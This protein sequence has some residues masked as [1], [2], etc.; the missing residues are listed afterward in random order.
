MVRPIAFASNPE[1]AGTNAFQ[2]FA[3]APAQAQAQAGAIAEFTRLRD[4]LREA[5]VGVVE[6][7]DTPE[8]WTPDSIF[9]NNWFSTHADGSY[10]LYPMLAPNRRRERRDDVFRE[11]LPAA[12]YAVGTR[13][14]LAPA[15]QHG[16][17]LE[18]TGSLV[19]DRVNRVAYACRS[20][21]THE[22]IA[23]AFAE[24]C[25]YE[26]V[27]FDARDAAGQAIYHTNVLMAVGEHFAVICAEAIPA[28][29]REAVLGRLRASGRDIID[30]SFAQM[31]GFAGNVLEL[32]TADGGRVVAMS[33][34]AWEAFTP[35]QRERL[36]RRARLLPVDIS[37]IEQCAGGSVRCMLAEVHL[38]RAAG[39]T[40]AETGA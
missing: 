24:R 10:V 13:I 23:R 29:E 30:I 17:F 3:E 36:G 21:R 8:S 37:T 31:N 38:P 16:Q 39:T 4:A 11:A 34:A 22:A 14:D 2:D 40:A 35:D 12:G 15:E 26:L 18:G 1:T 7:T 32:A 28:A 5:G 33:Q 19:L 25:G 9:P 27:L 6:V 20:P